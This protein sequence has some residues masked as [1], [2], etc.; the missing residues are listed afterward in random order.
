MDIV[1]NTVFNNS[2]LP[3]VQFPG[4]S[5]NF[6]AA[7]G[8]LDYT[9]GGKAWIKASGTGSGTPV[10]ERVSGA[11]KLQSPSPNSIA[12]VDGLAADGVLTTT[13]G[14][15]G[16]NQAAIVLRYV[17]RSNYI[18][19]GMASS[20]TR[21][22]LRKLVGGSAT[23]LA[24]STTTATN[25]DVVAITMAGSAISVEVNGVAVDSLSVAVTDFQASTKHGIYAASTDYGATFDGISFAAA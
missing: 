11:A 12:V 20:G 6:N 4:F 16:I 22:Q 13:I 10:W 8:A 24:N 5:D 23:N 2:A 3:K 17:D 7:D 14:S 25:G 15:I 9:P 19:L 1:L 21:Y 18:F